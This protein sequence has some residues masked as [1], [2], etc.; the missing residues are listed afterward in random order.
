MFCSQLAGFWPIEIHLVDSLGLIICNL[1]SLRLS[2][3]YDL[4]LS[5]PEFEDD[6]DEATD[7]LL[8]SILE[9]WKELREEEQ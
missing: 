3:V 1:S 7:A 4:V 9:S 2:E 8:K 6:P 5:L